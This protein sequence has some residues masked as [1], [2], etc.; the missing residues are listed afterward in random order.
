MIRLDLIRTIAPSI[1]EM[2]S[3]EQALQAYIPGFRSQNGFALCIAHQEDTPSMR[4]GPVFAHCFGCGFHG[5]S[6]EIVKR[7]FH[8]DTFRAMEKLNED[9]DLGLPLG[10][11]LTLRESMEIKERSAAIAKARYNERAKRLYKLERRLALEQEL[12]FLED[13]RNEVRPVDRDAPY[14]LFAIITREIERLKYT[15]ACEA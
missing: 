9:F 1:R 10:R 11:K 6:L 14:T 5:D 8:L 4:I 2:V 7:I 13:L 15:L 3:P 12:F